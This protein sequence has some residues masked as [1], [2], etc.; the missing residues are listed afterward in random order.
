MSGYPDDV[1]QVIPR[2]VRDR[3]RFLT[4]RFTEW[5]HALYEAIPPSMPREL[6]VETESR[7]RRLAN[8]YATGDLLSLLGRLGDRAFRIQLDAEE[9]QARD[10]ELAEPSR[11]SEGR[12]A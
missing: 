2:T 11:N 7:F 12:T 8:E 1:P 10:A 6:R 4:S 5:K 9:L 3:A